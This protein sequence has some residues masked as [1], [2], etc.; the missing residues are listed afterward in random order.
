VL[1]ERIEQR[2]VDALVSLR[3]Y[4]GFTSEG[5][6]RTAALVDLTRARL[7]RFDEPE[8]LAE[9]Y[10]ATVLLRRV[11]IDDPT[12]QTSPFVRDAGFALR[13]VELKT[14]ARLSATALPAWLGEWA[15]V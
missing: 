5:W 11:R 12:T 6:R 8:T 9:E 1:A 2:W 13:Y 15:V 3:Q 7:E 4:A 14:G 10:L